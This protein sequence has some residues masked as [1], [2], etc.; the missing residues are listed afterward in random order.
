[1]SITTRHTPN[2]GNVRKG[3]L[4]GQIQSSSA[5]SNIIGGGTQGSVLFIGANSNIDQDNANFYWDNTKDSLLISQKNLTT[6][7]RML[8]QKTSTGVEGTVSTS[9]SS[10]AV[11]GVGTYFFDDFNL[12]DQIVVNGEARTVIGITSQ[13]ALTTDAWTATNVS[14]TYTRRFVG[15]GLVS[16]TASSGTVT[17]SGTSF[18][19]TLGIGDIIT[20]GNESRTISAIAS[21]TSLTTDAWTN[22]NTSQTFY[23]YKQNDF[24]IR[25]N[26]IQL[27]NRPAQLFGSSSIITVIGDYLDRGSSTA[28]QGSI[29]LSQTAVSSNTNLQPQ[30]VFGSVSIGSR[31][32]NNWTNGIGISGGSFNV[33]TLS[34]A[35]GTITAISS[36]RSR[37]NYIA[38]GMTITNHRTF[39]AENF[40]NSGTVTNT[41]GFYCSPLTSGTQTNIPYSFY[42]E[43]NA[44]YNYFAGNTGMRTAIPLSTLDVTGSVGAAIVTKV[45]ADSPYTATSTDYTILADATGGAITI[46]LPTAASSTRRIYVVKKID[47]SGNNIVIDGD[48]GETIDGAATQTISVQYRTLMIQSNGTAWFI[49]SSLN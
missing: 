12:G 28:I 35:T 42:A 37:A 30:G 18:L 2:S 16:T 20:V 43:D 29:T 11:T 39:W 47:A 41:Y 4:S 44:A 32:V 3:T 19:N 48:G 45:F 46:N 7:Q 26:I 10:G 33:N 22:N 24:I 17:G 27:G 14:A 34:G 36:V 25:D 15:S 38:A 40:T 1:M 6:K 5:S 21:D 49:L 13:T 31:N 8:V 9:A 23:Q